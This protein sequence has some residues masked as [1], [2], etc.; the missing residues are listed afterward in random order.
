[1]TT[2]ASPTTTD[3]LG[4]VA[5]YNSG[6]AFTIGGG[7]TGTYYLYV[8]SIS[9]TATNT[10]VGNITIGGVSYHKYGPY[11]F[12]NTNPTVNLTVTEHTPAGNDVTIWKSAKVRLTEYDSGPATLSSNTLKYYFTDSDSKV[13]TSDSG[14]STCNNNDDFGLYKKYL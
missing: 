10:S 12:D 11:K 9:D 8:K 13:P 6:S 7:K 14:W 3:Q 2:N 1:M 5:Y 4:S